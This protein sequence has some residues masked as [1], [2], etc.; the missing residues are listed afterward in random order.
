LEP[1]VRS[2]SADEELRKDLAALMV[3][4]GDVLQAQGDQAGALAAYRTA[5]Q[6]HFPVSQTWEELFKSIGGDYNATEPFQPDEL[7]QLAVNPKSPNDFRRLMWLI[8]RAGAEKDSSFRDLLDKPELRRNNQVNLALM[9]YDYS[10]NGHQK[11]LDELLDRLTKEKAGSDSSVVV[12]LGFIDEWDRIP[13]A[14]N[15]HFSETDGAGGISQGLLPLR[16]AYLFPRHSLQYE[17]KAGEG[18]PVK[19]NE[20]REQSKDTD[21]SRKASP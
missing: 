13:K 19:R 8:H 5:Q 2:K 4:I 9:G 11:A 10:V 18:A 7:R 3:K 20:K 21:P 1:L 16:R 17:G 14:V 15:A 12:A 6:V